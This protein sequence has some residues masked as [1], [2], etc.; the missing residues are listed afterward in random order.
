MALSLAEEKQRLE[1]AG[2][3]LLVEVRGSMILGL[4]EEAAWGRAFQKYFGCRP[5]IWD[6][7]DYPQDPPASA[8]SDTEDEEELTPR[9]F[10]E[11]VEEARGLDRVGAGAWREAFR[12]CF[13]FTAFL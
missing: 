11:A 1:N 7:P 9:Q 12:R 6:L 2:R 10:L 3:G 5:F 13:G 4:E 8:W